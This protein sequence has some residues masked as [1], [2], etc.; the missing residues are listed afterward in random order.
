M[1]LQV[2]I[3]NSWLLGKLNMF[4]VITKDGTTIKNVVGGKDHLCCVL[5]R[6]KGKTW[7]T[8]NTI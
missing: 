3:K 1:K 8:V 7:G 4:K 5:F 6:C 2:G